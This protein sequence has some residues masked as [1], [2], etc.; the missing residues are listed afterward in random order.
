MEMEKDKIRIFSGGCACG[1]IRYAATTEPVAQI[2]CQ[3]RDC[4]M[5]SGTGHGSYLVF[6]G[7]GAVDITGTPTVWT[8]AGDSGKRKDHAFCSVC[9]TPVCLTFPAT[10]G[11]TAIHAS[12]LDDP[13]HF[14]P[15]LRT[16]ASSGHA[17]DMHDPQLVTFERMPPS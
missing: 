16:Y 13:E 17:W 7:G 14:A 6:A 5:R 11:V 4:Q 8:I 12:S 1:A 15:T 2:H 9:G 3:C 10:P